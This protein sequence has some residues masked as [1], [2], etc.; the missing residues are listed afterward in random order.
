MKL[1]K[2]Y[3]IF[4]LGIVMIFGGLSMVLTNMGFKPIISENFVYVGILSTIIGIYLLYWTKKNSLSVGDVVSF[5]S[6]YG[7]EVEEEIRRVIG[8]FFGSWPES[9][10][11]KMNGML[12]CVDAWW[13]MRDKDWPSKIKLYFTVPVRTKKL[14]AVEVDGT[15]VRIPEA[16]EKYTDKRDLDIFRDLANDFKNIRAKFF[17]NYSFLWMVIDIEAVEG[18]RALNIIKA[19]V[20]AFLKLSKIFSADTEFYKKSG[21]K[22]VIYP[23]DATTKSS[24]KELELV[25]SLEKLESKRHIAGI[26][27]FILWI[28][29]AYIAYLIG[30]EPIKSLVIL[31]CIGLAVFFLISGFKFW[32]LEGKKAL[33]KWVMN[34]EL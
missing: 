23:A 34:A 29:L 4:G 33:R 21:E 9:R 28:A 31:G 18:K 25:K 11:G 19:S 22:K 24:Y 27:L 30:E 17:Y 7:F 6:A 14:G 2:G 32:K 16:Y 5:L 1:L 12:V 3:I 10:I 26:M 8:V 13:M 20:D 15:R